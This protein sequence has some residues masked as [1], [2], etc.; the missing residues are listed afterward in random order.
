MRYCLLSLLLCSLS[1]GQI[2]IFNIHSGGAVGADTQV[3][4]EARYVVR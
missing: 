2:E 4:W 3:A 1:H